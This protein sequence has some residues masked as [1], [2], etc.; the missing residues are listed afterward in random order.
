MMNFVH[1]DAVGLERSGMIDMGWE[2]EIPS[3]FAA[4]LSGRL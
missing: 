2:M 4:L 3:C 1:T